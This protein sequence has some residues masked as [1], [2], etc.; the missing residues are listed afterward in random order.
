MP[1]RGVFLVIG[2]IA[3]VG[4][5]GA[6]FVR[7]A[8]SPTDDL[9]SLTRARASSGTPSTPDIFMPP[10]T[11]PSVPSGRGAISGT[12]LVQAQPVEAVPPVM[13]PG[14]AAV[15]PG[16]AAAKEPAA[17]TMPGSVPVVPSATV[18]TNAAPVA[19][20]SQSAAPMQAP[21]AAGPAVDE[22][23]LRYFAQQGDVRRL[24]AE[25]ARLRALYPNWYPPSD[26]SAPVPV[27]DAP[28]DNMWKLYSQGQYAAARAAIADRLAS[29]PNWKVPADLLARLDVGEQRERLINA[30]NAKQWDTVVQIAAATPSL[31]T[32]ADVDVLWR[33]AE[34]FARSDRAGRARDVDVYV[35]TNCQDPKE[36]LATVQKAMAYLGDAELGDLLAL[37]RTG[38]NG[39]G[40]FAAV[41]GDIARRRVGA[42]AKDAAK[43]AP[44]EDIAL[45]EQLARAGTKADD[46]VLLG[47]YLFTHNDADGA[48]TWFQ[49]AKTRA[50]TPE[51][52]R[53]LAYALNALD[54]PAE[55]EAAAYR[56]RDAGAENKEVYLVVA[57]ALLAIDPPAKI[58]PEVMARMAKA[59]SEAK[60]PQGAQNLG[61]YA[62]NTGQ[63]VAAARWFSAALTW[64]PDTEPAAFG[65]ALAAQKLGNKVAFAQVLRVW[66]PRSQRIA[67]LAD[68][69][70]KAGIRPVDTFVLPPSIANPGAV[71]PGRSGAVAPT[72]R[73]ASDYAVPTPEGAFLGP[74]AAA[75]AVEAAPVRT[76]RVSS[77]GG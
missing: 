31:L 28:L 60:Y 63:T 25:I 74:D 32:C 27:T 40:E 41:R 10:T 71:Q 26:M 24:N 18:P 64:K 43:T 34:A 33:L 21:A 50:D 12:A 2:S 51:I 42:A 44:A 3:I 35:L 1:V 62:Y 39:Q 15:L 49:L 76:T 19:G 47:S 22:T 57:T 6:V 59:I 68:P 58:E 9:T 45:L 65:L 54:R 4:I 16:A 72:T 77:S 70:K 46:A 55:A 61:W 13:M 37:E 20:G 30:S 5:L 17:S 48:V 29:D 52:A 67:D 56:W 73:V 38:A 53:G 66:G 69:T 8:A 11:T 23:A 75:P 7:Q 14:G 36:R